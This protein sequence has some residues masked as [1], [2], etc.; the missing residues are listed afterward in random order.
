MLGEAS[1]QSAVWRAAGH[2]HS[3]SINIPPDTCQ[4][5]GAAA[6]ERLIKAAGGE[7]SRITLEM[8]ESAMM[9]PARTA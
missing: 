2:D 6:I 8:T 3:I 1:R 9:S 4:Q 7:P 5:I